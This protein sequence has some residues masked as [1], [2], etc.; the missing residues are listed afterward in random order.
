MTDLNDK[1]K[2]M[3]HYARG[4][5]VEERYIENGHNGIWMGAYKPNFNW[6]AFDYR[7]KEQSSDES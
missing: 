7:I 3:Q 4:G 6:V 2:V 5:R 1:I